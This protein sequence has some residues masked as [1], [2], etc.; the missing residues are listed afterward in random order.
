MAFR[1]FAICKN[2]LSHVQPTLLSKSSAKQTFP[3]QIVYNAL[4]KFSSD[5][6][7]SL[8]KKDFSVLSDGTSTTPFTAMKLLGNIVTCAKNAPDGAWARALFKS[9][10]VLGTVNWF[11]GHKQ[12]VTSLDFCSDR[13]VSASLDG[14][15]KVWDIA[16]TNLLKTL[17]HGSISVNCIQVQGYTLVSGTSD[18][19]ASIWNLR[20]YT[21][22]FVLSGHTDSIQ[23]IAINDNLVA[24]GSADN[25]CRIWTAD[26]GN[27]KHVLKEHTGEISC[28]Q[29]SE[30]TLVTGSLDKTCKSWDPETGTVLQTFQHDGAVLALEFEDNTLATVTDDRTC[31]IWNLNDGSAPI[32]TL[33]GHTGKITC[34]RLQGDILVT[35]S[36]DRTLRLWDIKAGTNK[37][38]QQYFCAINRLVLRG[39]LVIVGLEYGSIVQEDLSKYRLEK[40][41]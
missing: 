23:C 7:P 9:D 6:D 13:L 32:T 27:R 24:T 3:S 4:R 34:M 10:I 26:C 31:T 17:D 14:T 37:I 40:S 11:A 41:I 2:Y 8:K 30:G 15:C 16:T 18:T 21:R 20:T 22:D 33:K 19:T 25:T 38:I 1:S 29:L 35:G 5:I 36:E 12:L 28:L 39:N